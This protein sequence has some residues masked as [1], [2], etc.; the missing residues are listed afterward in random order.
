MEFIVRRDICKE[1]LDKYNRSIYPEL[2]SRIIEIGILTLK[3]SFNKLSFSPYELDDIIESLNEQSKLENFDKF[4]HLKKLT[5]KK[6]N[7]EDESKIMENENN[8]FGYN[9]ITFNDKIFDKIFINNT[10]FYDSNYII[11]ESK[12]F[13]NKQ[14]Y[15]KRLENPLFK[16]QNKNVYPFW[17]WNFPD[18]EDE[19]YKNSD[20]LSKSFNNHRFTISSE[21]DEEKIFKRNSYNNDNIYNNENQKV[22]D[23]KNIKKVNRNNYKISYDRNLNII[24]VEQSS[25]KTKKKSKNKKKFI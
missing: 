6:F 12:S 4:K 2:L 8:S 23:N 19:I 18:S 10:N 11:P 15:N 13:R 24:G 3:L 9:T 1:F 7:I 25:N 21:C 16:T 20:F 17:W 14:L 22:Y 5:N